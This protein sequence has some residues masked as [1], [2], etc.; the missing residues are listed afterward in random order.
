[1]YCHPI[2]DK[3]GSRASPMEDGTGRLHLRAQIAKLRVSGEHT[4]RT[5]SDFHC[6]VDNHA[7]AT[8]QLWIEDSQGKKAGILSLDG[9][10]FVRTDFAVQEWAFY[11]IKLSQET[12]GQGDDDPAWD[13]ESR[14]LLGEPGEP[15]INPQES[16]GPE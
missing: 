9:T 3:P 11:F 1:M 2:N 10:T 5:D 6:G 8:C 4:G 14:T 7:K 13:V 15:A 16:E 12:Y